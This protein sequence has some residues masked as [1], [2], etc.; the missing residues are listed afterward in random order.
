MTKIYVLEGPL[1]GKMFEVTELASIGR[2]ESC[3]VRL[4]GHHISRIHARLEKAG[5]AMT[6]KDNGS[7]NGI[8]VNGRSVK[9]S[10][11]RSND[12][13]EIGEHLLVFEPT[14]DPEQLPRLGATV[15]ESISDPFAPGEPDERLQKL[16]GV[17]ASL[18]A[19]ETE[20]EIAQ[21][22]LEALLLAISAHRGF[23]MV[24]DAKGELKPA[25]RKVPSGD[26]EFALSNIIQFQ[27]SKQRRAVIASDVRRQQPN[28]GKRVGI[29]AAPLSAKI[30]FL[31]LV[32][33]DVALGEGETRPGFRTADL[34]FASALSV[35][36]A[37]RIGH[38]RRL[39]PI[40]LVGERPL[41]DLRAAFEKECVVEALRQQ[42]GDIAGAA[43]VL[44]LTRATLDEKLKIMGLVSTPPA[45]PPAAPSAD[46]KSVQI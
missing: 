16:L 27:L 18:V 42:K 46:W 3:A 35:F 40:G 24:Q 44:G 21:H 10:P 12:Q 37:A 45:S 15:L 9:E 13:I 34:R 29:L 26:E 28:E 31:G 43:K 8:F 2:G 38:L 11:L 19:M 1:R 30:G 36:A 17:A 33:L 14:G 5:E 20:K 6:I 4:E 39:A 32:Y 23:V 7:R 22:L 25:A 41:P